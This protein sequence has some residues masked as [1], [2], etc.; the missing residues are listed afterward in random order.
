MLIY[1]RLLQQNQTKNGENTLC[2][3]THI[4]GVHRTK[5]ILSVHSIF[6]N[7]NK[8]V[9]ELTPTRILQKF[10]L[11]QISFKSIGNI[12]TYTVETGQILF[13]KLQNTGSGSRQI[14]PL[15]C[16]YNCY[17]RQF[18]IEDGLGLHFYLIIVLLTLP[19]S[20][21]CNNSINID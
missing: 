15:T 6:S 5:Q 4:R 7:N 20:I 19:F 8:R 13:F 17:W 10:E 2:K 18:G 21:F 16:S 3:H 12:S 11:I 14:G 9:K 1:I